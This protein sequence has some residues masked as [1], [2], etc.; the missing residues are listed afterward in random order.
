MTISYAEFLSDLPDLHSWDG[1]T[2]N[3][4]GFERQHL[5]PL[6]RFLRGRLPRR[7]EMLETE[8]G[9]STIAMLLMNPNKV[10]SIAPDADLFERIFAYCDARQIDRSTLEVHIEESEWA[11][12]PM[13]R[14]HHAT[15]DFALLDGSH[16]WP[17]TFIDLFYVET[18]LRQ[19]GFLMID[20]V[21]L[22]SVKEMVR[23]LDQQPGI[24]LVLDLQKARV[25]EKITAPTIFARWTKEPYIVSRTQEYA[26]WQNPFAN[27]SWPPIV[28]SGKFHLL[29]RLFKKDR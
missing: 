5:E 24:R 3:T 16:A 26:M 10:I 25:Y 6:E 18:M 22:H 20:D 7:A 17:T 19:G 28:G 11:L 13:A 27:Y 12:P 23:L 14:E 1:K 29:H 9:C 4:G 8:A 2:W 21:Q 15:M